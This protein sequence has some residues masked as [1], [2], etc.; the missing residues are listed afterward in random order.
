MSASAASKAGGFPIGAVA[1]HALGGL[2]LAVGF[3]GLFVPELLGAF[4]ALTDRMTAWTLLGA[5]IALDIGAALA[6]IGH[7]RKRRQAAG[8]A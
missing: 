4:P 8:R 7:A 2:F 3:V 1:V 6:I 5:G